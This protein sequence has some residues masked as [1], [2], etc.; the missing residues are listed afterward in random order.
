MKCITKKLII[1]TQDKESVL[2]NYLKIIK[3]KFNKQ[4]LEIM[5]NIAETNQNIE[6]E[7]NNKK[8]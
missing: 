8:K 3:D 6:E 1:M 2:R 4:T 7:V 5:Q